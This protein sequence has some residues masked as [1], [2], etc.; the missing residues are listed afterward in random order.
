MPTARFSEACERNKDF[1]LKEI[2]IFF[3]DSTAILEVGSGTGQ[4][5]VYFSHRLPWLAWQPT[6]T[7]NYLDD[8]SLRISEEAPENVSAPIDL[9]V[10]M[11]PWPIGHYDGVFSANTLHIMSWSCVEN[12]FRGVGETLKGGGALCI[13]GPFRYGGEFT[14]ESNRQ[15]DQQLKRL[16]AQKG[17]RDFE[18]V[19]ELAGAEQLELAQDI[20]MPANNQLLVWRR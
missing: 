7:A 12:F 14:S 10:R 1:I 20:A 3:G 8:L 19:N 18:A 4:H 15:F 6:D 13:Y 16:D 17:I 11:Q 2:A 5:A 9:D